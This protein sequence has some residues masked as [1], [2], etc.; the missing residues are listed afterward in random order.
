MSLL[1]RNSSPRLIKFDRTENTV[2]FKR[3]RFTENM[4][5]IFVIGVFARYDMS[6]NWLLSTMRT[7][8]LVRSEKV[9]RDVEF[10]PLPDRSSSSNLLAKG[11]NALLGITPS[12]FSSSFRLVRLWK[13]FKPNANVSTRS[14]FL[15]RSSKLIEVEPL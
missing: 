15:P 11:E 6:C 14:R 8:I 5:R 9:V 1:S 7:R 10:S 4:R 2:E 12:S 3:L 13:V